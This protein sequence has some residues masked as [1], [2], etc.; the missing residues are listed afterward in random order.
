[1]EGEGMKQFVTICY[2]REESFKDTPGERKRQMDHYEEGIYNSEGCERDRY[3][4][5]YFALKNGCGRCDDGWE[6]LYGGE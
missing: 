1:M 5:V 3:V 2:D 6:W 4:S